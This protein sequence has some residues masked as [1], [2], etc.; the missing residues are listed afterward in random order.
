V[1][2]PAISPRFH[3][4]FIFFSPQAGRV[5]IMKLSDIHIR[6]SEAKL[7]PFLAPP[8]LTVVWWLTMWFNDGYPGQVL[9][10]T[11]DE[12]RVVGPVLSNLLFWIITPL[13][14]SLYFW[15][16][17]TR[18]GRIE[19]LIYAL[20]WPAGSVAIYLFLLLLISEGWSGGVR[21]PLVGA[22]LIS[23]IYAPLLLFT[24]SWLSVAIGLGTTLFL[25]EPYAK[26]IVRETAEARGMIDPARSQPA[27]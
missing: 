20:L 27:R 24:E 16:L 6:L 3:S 17:S 7:L 13:S 4:D 14:I 11:L 21:T 15:L 26:R 5:Q 1:V 2:S 23:G 18:R 25:T 22:A 10:G 9:S 12:F 8:A 19:R